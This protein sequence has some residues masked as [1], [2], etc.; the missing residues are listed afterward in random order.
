ML[1]IWVI[2]MRFFVE[3]SG[4]LCTMCTMIQIGKI[5]ISPKISSTYFWRFHAEK[6]RVSLNVL[7]IKPRICAKLGLQNVT[8]IKLMIRNITHNI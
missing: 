4:Q 7:G 5:H 1:H 2:R 8:N 6:E 3:K